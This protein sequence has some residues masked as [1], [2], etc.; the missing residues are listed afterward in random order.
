MTQ[1]EF[2]RGFYARY[3]DGYEMEDLTA[4]AAET[5]SRLQ[6]MVHTAQTQITAAQENAKEFERKAGGEML[7]RQ[8][9]ELELD[10]LKKQYGVDNG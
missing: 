7:M 1:D 8:Q 9:V 5:I 2:M 3:P 4:Y 10:T 6:G